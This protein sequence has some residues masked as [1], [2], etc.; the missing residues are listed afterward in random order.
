M[1]APL[2]PVCFGVARSVICRSKPDTTR[3]RRCISFSHVCHRAAIASCSRPANGL[4]VK[5]GGVVIGGAVCAGA[6]AGVRSN[7]PAPSSP[8]YVYETPLPS[9]TRSSAPEGLSQSMA[10]YRYPGPL[11]GQ[12]PFV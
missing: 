12:A 2:S 10:E 3:R 5:G 8:W 6:S 9:V 4:R 1:C 7:H 11:P